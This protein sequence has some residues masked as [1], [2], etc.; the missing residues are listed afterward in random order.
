MCPSS[1]SLVHLLPTT[2]SPRQEI[3]GAGKEGDTVSQSRE[4]NQRQ[5]SHCW[6]L[7]NLTDLLYIK[8]VLDSGH[9]VTN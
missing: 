1:F 4:L 3:E 8:L 7:E 9:A 6:D 2:N 5:G